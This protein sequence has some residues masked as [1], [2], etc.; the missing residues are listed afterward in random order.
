MHYSC[1]DTGERAPPQF[2]P[3]KSVLITYPGGMK[4]SVGWLYTEMV[5]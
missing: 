3:D 4:G 2:Q 5:Y 1:S